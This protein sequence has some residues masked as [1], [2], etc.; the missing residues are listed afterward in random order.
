LLELGIDAEVEDLD[1]KVRCDPHVGGLHVEVQHAGGVSVLE[2]ARDLERHVD[3]AQIRGVWV[4]VQASTVVIDQ[5][6]AE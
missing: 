2:G 1:S 3:P 6:R 4:F 5:V